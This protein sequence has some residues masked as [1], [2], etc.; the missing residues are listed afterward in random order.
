MHS[1]G[2]CFKAHISK[3]YSDSVLIGNF[4]TQ[5]HQNEK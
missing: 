2:S 1:T 3:K 4:A 5:E